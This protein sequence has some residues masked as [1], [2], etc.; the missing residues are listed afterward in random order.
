MFQK[1]LIANRGEI[2]VRIIR[3]CREMQIP[4]VAVYEPADDSAIHVRLANQSILLESDHSFFDQ[5]AL[6]KIARETGCDAI[7]PGY[8]FL[9]E[10]CGFAEACAAAGITL[11]GPSAT[12]MKEVVFKQHALHRVGAADVPTVTHSDFSF[13]PEE[14][15]GILYTANRL[16][17]PIIIKSGVGGRGPGER[18][19][20]KPPQLMAALHRAKRESRRFYSEDQLYLEK[21]ILP[22]HLV[23]VQIVGDRHGNLIHLGDREGSILTGSRKIIEESPA[24]CLDDDQRQAMHE[25]ALTIG[26]LFKYDNIGTV[27][28]LVDG[29]GN[30]FF[31]EVKAR[32]QAEHPLTELRAHLDLVRLQ[33]EIAA[34][35]PLTIEQ[36]SVDLRTHTMMARIRAENPRKRFLPAPGL[37]KRLRF[38]GG[39]GVRVDSYITVG[40]R[41]PGRYD[42]LFAK[43]SVSG[44]TREAC[45]SRFQLALNETR[46]DGTATNL[47]VLRQAALS[48]RFTNGRYTTEFAPQDSD[49]ERLSATQRRQLAAAA[50]VL[51]AYRNQRHAPSQPDQFRRGWHQAS[52]RLP[53]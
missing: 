8:G 32:L 1:I 24:P 35:N 4:T 31:S 51:Y 23:G 5:D 38:P 29:K 47:I 43:I 45:L 27:E 33:I 13:S 44:M 52:R 11:I 9:A 40:S 37:I 34:G 39:H 50:A 49:L 53:E 19:V 25:A 6:L 12:V 15:E 41:I 18:L 16:G 30:F 46:V 42:P 21:A 48:P 26:R 22:V 20:M 17:Y 28:F 3:T 14:D 10:N 7:H 2:A 36:G